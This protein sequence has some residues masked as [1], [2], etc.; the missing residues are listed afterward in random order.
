MTSRKV[1]IRDEIYTRIS[2]GRT[3][4]NYVFNTFGI[5]RTYHPYRTLEALGKE[6]PTGIV[7]VVAM[8]PSDAS[9]RGRGNNSLRELPVMIVY[10]RAA[11]DSQDFGLIDDLVE[12]VEQLEDTCRNEVDAEGFS[13]TR[14]EYLRDE[15]ELPFAF[16]GMREGNVF[17]AYFTAYYNFALE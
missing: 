2:L 12:L 11:V 15:N 13:W 14:L 4:G 9:N 7:Y 5:L 3:N 16:M 8:A 10:Q 17:E 6:Y 1:D